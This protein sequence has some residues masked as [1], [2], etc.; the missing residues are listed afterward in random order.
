MHLLF[1]YSS[2][3][4]LYIDSAVQ[5]VEGIRPQ[6]T[7]CHG[8]KHPHHSQD[9]QQPRKIEVIILQL[10]ITFMKCLELTVVCM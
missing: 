1:L 9:D 6:G 2:G 4:P 3:Q 10:A 5:Y 8:E 7:G